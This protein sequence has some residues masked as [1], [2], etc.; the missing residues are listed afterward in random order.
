MNHATAHAMD[1]RAQLARN[2]VRTRWVMLGFVL[3]YAGIGLLFDA[4][5][6]GALYPN[7]TAMQIL[8]ALLSF[9]I[10]PWVMLITLGIAALSLWV[11]FTWH[12][13]LMLLGTGAKAIDANS[14][15][16]H[17]R[18]L[19]NVAEEMK[20]AAGMH[21]LP[22]IYI[23][24]KAQ[25]NAFASGYSEKSALIAVT[26]G[27]V[28]KL[29]RQELC[30]VVA[31]ELSH[32]RHGD[33]KL[34]MVASLLSNLMLIAIDAVFY[35]IIYTPRHNRSNKSQGWLLVVVVILRYAL[36]LLTLVMMLFLSRSREYMA[37]AGAVELMRDNEAMA[38]ALIKIRDD[39]LANHESY[40]QTAKQSKHEN[41]RRQA[42]IFDPIHAQVQSTHSPTDWFS[43]HPSFEKRLA[44][45]GYRENGSTEDRSG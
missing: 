8:G 10:I 37:D 2:Q 17:E 30:A 1:W 22:K 42:Y 7:A 12:D 14:Q 20:V 38:K 24:P 21:Y 9:K 3:L 27:L 5:W 13:K 4:F 29:N 19:Y 41:V 23:M 43:T 28:E 15:A 31:H 26:Q 34:T 11:T 40:S 33:I 25:M 32:I 39:G 16:P 18:Q 36:P 44:A 6:A 35:H 45:L